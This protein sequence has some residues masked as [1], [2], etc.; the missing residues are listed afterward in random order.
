MRL[1]SLCRWGTIY[2]RIPSYLEMPVRWS[3]AEKHSF[4]DFRQPVEGECG[5]PRAVVIGHQQHCVSSLYVC[6]A[7]LKINLKQ[8]NITINKLI[9]LISNGFSI[10]YP[11]LYRTPRW[12]VAMTLAEREAFLPRS[13][14]SLPRSST[15]RRWSISDSA[16]RTEQLGKYSQIL[17]PN[18]ASGTWSAPQGLPWLLCIALPVPVHSPETKNS[19]SLHIRLDRKP[20]S[21]SAKIPCVLSLGFFS[22]SV[23][24]D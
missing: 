8:L 23:L 18:K 24:S 16:G 19:L 14:A 2:T 13:L 10:F 5:W 11:E 3:R 12:G 21:L 6:Y 17:S 1:K 15:A 9:N 22:L 4:Q 7:T 20:L